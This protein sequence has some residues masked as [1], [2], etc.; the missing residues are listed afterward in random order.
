MYCIPNPRQTGTPP[1]WPEPPPSGGGLA[2]SSDPNNLAVLGTDGQLYVPDEVVVGHAPDPA[3][4]HLELWVD[5][6]MPSTGGSNYAWVVV[7]DPAT[8]IRPGV[9]YVLWV[10]GVVKP[11][12]MGVG[13]LWVKA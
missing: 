5:L 2:L 11:V 6:D 9:Q 4:S 12:N 8:D 7:V 1:V 10:G 3:D 13:D